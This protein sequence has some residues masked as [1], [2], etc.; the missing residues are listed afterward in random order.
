MLLSIFN[1]FDKMRHSLWIYM[2]FL[3]NENCP[4]FISG[5]NG[6]KRKSWYK[7]SKLRLKQRA[8]P[9]WCFTIL[10]AFKIRLYVATI[11]S[12]SGELLNQLI[13]SFCTAMRLAIISGSLI[14]SSGVIN[15]FELIYVF[16]GLKCPIVLF[17]VNE[18]NYIYWYQLVQLLIPYLKDHFLCVL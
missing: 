2:I 7:L 4:V 17:A 13:N 3:P 11:F 12:F 1:T 15:V 6:M 10:A 14:R 5:N 16:H 9:I 18:R 8:T